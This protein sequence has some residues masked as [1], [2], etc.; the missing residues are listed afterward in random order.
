MTNTTTHLVEIDHL[1]I[2]FTGEQTAKSLGGRE[3][4]VDVPANLPNVSVDLKR[5]TDALVQLVENA[6]RAIGH[7]VGSPLNTAFQNVRH[8][9][10]MP[11]FG[12]IVRPR[13]V[14]PCRN[15]GDD[16]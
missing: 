3:V 4:R 14:L 6:H 11:N 8:A 5:I 1:S 12:Q 10:L 13:R 9:K 16:F 15:A 2:R 7:L